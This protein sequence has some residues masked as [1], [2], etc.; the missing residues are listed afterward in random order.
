M[1]N[2]K[3]I[4]CAYFVLIHVCEIYFETKINAHFFKINLLKF[5]KYFSYKKK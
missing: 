2:L 5:F 1:D 4:Q 3:K